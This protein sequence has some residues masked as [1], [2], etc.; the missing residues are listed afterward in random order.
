MSRKQ[1]TYYSKISVVS[2]SNQSWKSILSL[3]T[4]LTRLEATND[5]L[6][7]AYDEESSSEASVEFQSILKQDSE[8]MDIVIDMVSQL[9][10]LKEEVERKRRELD[11]SHTQNLAW[12]VSHTGTGTDDLI[13][14]NQ[15]RLDQFYL[16]PPLTRV[17]KPNQIDM[18]PY[19]GDILKW[20]EFWDLF[21]ASVHKEKKVCHYR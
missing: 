11:T 2:M 20:K 4:K 6:I 13:T 16:Q 14:S 18:P 10:V 7:D 5:K 12:A 8:F 15:T 19:S 1:I 17:V 21:E 9:K 3:E